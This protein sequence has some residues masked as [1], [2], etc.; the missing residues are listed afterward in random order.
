M[1]SHFEAKTHLIQ[2]Q[3]L[4]GNQKKTSLHILAV[5]K[6]GCWKRAVRRKNP[7]WGSLQSVQVVCF[8]ESHDWREGMILERDGF[9]GI[10]SHQKFCCWLSDQ[11]SAA[12]NFCLI[13]CFNAVVVQTSITGHHIFCSDKKRYSKYW[14]FIPKCLSLLLLRH[15]TQNS[16]VSSHQSFL[17][18]F[19]F[20]FFLF[21]VKT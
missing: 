19:F 14:R 7:G 11:I 16:S 10:I 9:R 1:I 15:F 20:L 2:S 18:L 6:Q 3:Q 13:L 5:E 21:G 12:M 4:N 17:S 8:G